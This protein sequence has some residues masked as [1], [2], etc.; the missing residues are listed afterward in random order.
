MKVVI[1]GGGARGLF[2]AGWL[3]KAGIDTVIVEHSQSV[4]KKILLTGKGRCNVTNNCGID[5][6]LKNVGTNP[7]FLYSA[8]N[9]FSPADTINFFTELGVPLKTE[10]GRR[11]FPKSD[12]AA[13]ILSALKK[14]SVEAELI[15]DNA[16]EIIYTDGK[17]TAVK[18]EKGGII[19]CRRAV[20]ATGGLSY[21]STG[22][23]GDG[24]IFAQKAGHNIVKPTASLVPLVENGKK[25]QK[26]MGLSLRNVKLT[27]KKR[28]KE[29][30]SDR[31]EMLFTHFG[32]SG[33][34]VLS[35]SCQMKE[36]NLQ[37]YKAVIDLKPALSE[38]VLDRRIQ[39]DFEKFHLRAAQNCLDLLLPK[40]MIDVILDDWGID[41]QKPVNQITR[42]ERLKLVNLIKN[43]TI[44]LQ[45]KYK[46]DVAVI[47]AGGVSTKEIYPKTMESKIKSGLYFIGE[48][49]D[50]DG[51]T[52]GYNLQIAFSTAKAA[53]NGI[54]ERQN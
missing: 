48:V 13:D 37:K 25:C 54:T 28:Q 3:S 49:I 29:I 32:I 33:P 21:K 50:V 10:R 44:P 8:I 53:A 38:E 46:I 26:M 11:V 40:S 12:R 4:G 51:Y 24:Y 20:V 41:R 16:K 36:E 31:G 39:R 23:T 18:L 42:A 2:C 47:T 19:P 6:F 14:W 52:G 9:A 1:I 35:A 27:I 5:T 45:S 30:Y 43:F 15:F 22:S 34:L 17:V 7:K